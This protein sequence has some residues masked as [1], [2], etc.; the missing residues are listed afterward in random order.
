MQRRSIPAV[1]EE[2][3]ALLEIEGENPFKVKAYHN[4][5]KVLSGVEDLESIIQSDR[6]RDIQGIG[7]TLSKAVIEYSE[8]GK[9]AYHEELKLKVPVTLIELLQVPNLGPKKIKMLFEKLGISSLGE[10]E[11]ACKENRLIS[12]FRF[13]QKTQE[14]I[15]RGIEFVKRHKGEFLFGEIYPIA[16]RL[17]ERLEQIVPPELVAVCGSVRRR[18]ETVRDI[19]LLVAGEDRAKASR[20][21]VTM[22]ETEEVLAEGET[23]TSCRLLSGIEADLRVVDV[24]SFPFALMY[25]T[26]SKEHNVKVRG[27]AKKKGL[28]LNEYGLYE[29]D[30]PLRLSE[31]F[32][33]YRFL[34]LPFI[35]PELREDMGEIEAAKDGRLPDLL[36]LHD[37]KG[38]FHV[39]TYMS[40]GTDTLETIAKEAKTK[41]LAYIG[42]ADHSRSAYYAGGLT[43]EAVYRQWEEIDTFNGRNDEIYFFK[44][45]E[46]EIL[47]DGSLDYEDEVLDGFDFVV[48]SV[49]S[50][51]S[52]PKGDMERR[53][54]RAMQNPFTTILGHPTGRLLLARDGYDV[55]MKTIIQAAAEHGV[56]IELNA[57]PYRLD[58]DWRWLKY[59]KEQGVVIAIN[60]DAHSVREFG[61][62]FYGVGVARK[63]WQEKSDVLNTRDTLQVKEFLHRVR[64]EKKHQSHN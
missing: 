64:Y 25:F 32:D 36:D 15:L 27:I 1:L 62:L 8:T 38:T 44:G 6:L 30:K 47:P 46:S 45:I 5:A 11:Y 39:H 37:L 10:L 19:D 40:D 14:K 49:H 3:G 16:L 58:I 4:A 54:L 21:F 42:I 35:P 33:V 51:F 23:K 41:S 61:D 60:P 24:P 53:I 7:E 22:P 34:G 57:S 9:I 2:I 59:A 29:D 43:T 63:G 55:D 20:A 50:L 28:K 17:K 18:K 26:G 56:V 13:G 31:E 52:M 12:L 48:A